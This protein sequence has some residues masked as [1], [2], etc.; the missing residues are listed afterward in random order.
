MTMKLSI[1]PFYVL[2][3]FAFCVYIVYAARRS[4]KIG[5]PEARSIYLVIAGLFGWAIVATALG[6]CEVH[7]SP[8]LLEHVPLLWQSC[9][10]VV[11][12]VVAFGLSQT[13]RTAL[14]KL[15]DGTPAS[16]LVY[17]HALRIG[18][19]GTI[20]KALS[21]EITSNFPLWVG[22]PDF[23]Y[24][25]SAIIVGWLL[26]RGSIRHRTLAI[27]AVTGAA[28]ILV[29]IFGLMPYWMNEPG[30]MFIFE[31]PMVI[32]PSIVVPI[33]V[34]LDFLLAWKAIRA[35]NAT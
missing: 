35:G 34:L 18:A 19:L 26:G 22:I 27:W 12:L 4:G 30:F 21:G 20:V 8:W 17:V 7:T 13:V 33:F 9:V 10:P 5:T 3:V 31:F 23:T 16:W 11:I 28:I 24:G 2:F 1:L 25:V 15:A 29:P 32:A 6:L 14:C